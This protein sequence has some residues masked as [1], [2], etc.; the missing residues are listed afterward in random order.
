MLFYDL[1]Y[2]NLLKLSEIASLEC[3]VLM[4]ISTKIYA[5]LFKIAPNLMHCLHEWRKFTHI[6]CQKSAG[7]KCTKV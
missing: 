1:L 4:Q 5:N 3:E 6:R 7:I 2:Q